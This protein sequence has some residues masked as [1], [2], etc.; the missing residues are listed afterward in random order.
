[1]ALQTAFSGKTNFQIKINFLKARTKFQIN[2]LPATNWLDV[3][4]S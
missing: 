2:Q 1:M 3:F 4:I